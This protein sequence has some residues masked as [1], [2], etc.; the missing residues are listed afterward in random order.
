[1]QGNVSTAEKQKAL[2]PNL[3]DEGCA[4]AAKNAAQRTVGK[5]K[6][7]AKVKKN[8]RPHVGG[9]ASI[10]ALVVPPPI[11]RCQANLTRASCGLMFAWA[12]HL[13]L[14]AVTGAP[15]I[16]YSVIGNP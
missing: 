5:Q 4:W 15:E 13:S 11:C 2:V 14:G 1:L 9:R 6:A 16:G 3:E 8:A 7:L 10:F 12:N